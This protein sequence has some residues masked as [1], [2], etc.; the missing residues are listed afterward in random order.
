M[1]TWMVFKC[2]VNLKFTFFFFQWLKSNVMFNNPFAISEFKSVTKEICK[3]PS[4]F[5][6]LIFRKID[7]DCIGTVTRYA[8]FPVC[9]LSCKLMGQAWRILFLA[10]DHSCFTSVVDMSNFF[11]VLSNFIF[12]CFSV[13]APASCPL[14]LVY[15]TFFPFL[16]RLDNFI[17][18][19]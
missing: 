10:F 1:A 5:S 14:W 7:A 19:R 2:K 11:L 9:L 12:I 18:L 15:R 3:L 13:K 16:L 6:S 8:N 17:I 4:F